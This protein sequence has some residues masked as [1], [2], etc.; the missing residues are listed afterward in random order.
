MTSEH[1]DAIVIGAGQSGGPLA[2]ALARDGQKA[3]LI[4]RDRVGGTCVNTG[5]T[6]TKT[7]V[8]SA[9]VAYLV[10]RGADYGVDAGTVPVDMKVVRQ[11][12]S[13]VVESFHQGSLNAVL[14]TEGLE[15]IKGEARFTGPKSLDVT[16]NTGGT[17]AMTA[18]KIFI[19]TGSR[20]AVPPLPGIDAV[21]YY[22]STTIMEI[23]HVPEHLLV[24]GGGY[25]GL[26]FAQMFR[27]FGAKVTIIQRGP[28][29]LKNEDPDVASVVQEIM[30]EDGIDV[31]L[32]TNLESV[33]ETESG[34]AAICGTRCGQPVRIIGSHLLLAAGRQPNTDALDPAKSGIEVNKRGYIPVNDRLET[35]VDGI[36]AM[37]DVNGGPAFTHIS[38]NDFRVLTTNLLDG[39]C[40]SNRN[41]PLPYVL[42]VDPELAR[43]GLSEKQAAEQGYEVMIAKM[44]ASHIA[45]TIEMDETRGVLKVVIDAGTDQILGAAVM[46]V[47]GGEIMAFLQLAIATGTPYTT[48]R[49]MIFAHPTVSESLNNL[50]ANVE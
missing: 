28:Q 17:R 1:F 44:P 34:L 5:C 46:T 18:D 48:I 8:A 39:G 19:N 29:L 31:R 35:N 38:Y 13:D 14:A 36:W 4:E 33:E 3:A 49:D 10:N 16:L 32:N 30:E 24:V 6:P 11:R 43:I 37:G 50:F 7:M 9:R 2:S 41:R 45:R 23:D 12:K 42:Y 20:P 22:N 15:L 40:A 25:V 27:R 21:P 47:S 26:E